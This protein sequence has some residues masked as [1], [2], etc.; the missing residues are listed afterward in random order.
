MRFWMPCKLA[1]QS[2]DPSTILGG[3]AV[4]GLSVVFWGYV[5]IMT[6]SMSSRGTSSSKR[7]KQPF[8]RLIQQLNDRIRRT[9]NRRTHILPSRASSASILSSIGR[10]PRFGPAARKQGQFSRRICESWQWWL[11]ST[12]GLDLRAACD[13]HVDGASVAMTECGGSRKGIV[14]EMATVGEWTS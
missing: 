1:C 7:G 13:R 11:G 5:E 3:G 8:I 2:T 4:G 6:T 10:S 12:A 14:R 9:T